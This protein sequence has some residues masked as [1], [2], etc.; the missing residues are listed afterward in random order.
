M[1]KTKKKKLFKQIKKFFLN[2]SNF[3]IIFIVYLFVTLSAGLLLLLPISQQENQNVKFIDALFTA[4]S[5]FSDTGLTTLTTVT[6]WSDFGQ[7]LILILILSGGIG[8]FAL[9]FFLINVIFNKS[10]SINSRN[11][12]E[13]E[14]GTNSS[15]ELK[16]TI[17]VSVSF[18]FI[19]ILIA[20]MVLWLIFY[21]ET[22]V[23][24]WTDN[25]GQVHD[26][27]K[28]DPK[29]RVWISFKC[30]FFHAI[31]A[32]NNAGFDILSDS[33]LTPYYGVYSIQIV[34][35]ILLIIGGIGFPVIYDVLKFISYKFRKRTDFKFSLFSKVS[36]LTYL[37]V[38]LI[39]FGFVLIFEIGNKNGIWWTSSTKTGSYSNKMM[40]IIF[41]VFSTRNAGFTTLDPNTTKFT[42]ASL[43]IFAIMMFI[44]SAPSSTAGGIRTTTLA[45][46]VMSVWNKMR[47]IQGVR[48]F[49][50]NVDNE[51]IYSSFMVFVL[52]IFIVLTTSLICFTSLDTIWGEADSDKLNF[53]DIF[54]DVCSA[55]GTTGLSTGLTSSLN[56]ISKLAI[57]LTMFIGQL[58]ISSTLLVWKKTN[59]KD[60]FSYIH[61]N[62]LIG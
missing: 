56:L 52:S 1:N 59:P 9:K 3:Q 58:G 39:G 48:A 61:E 46:I 33:S 53:A 51:T 14:R 50:R 8:I 26:Y 12:L 22:G 32:I 16:K 44:G 23:F 49:K 27:T 5:A 18:L 35:I 21:Y 6:T 34:F 11:V 60:N 43:V 28:Y 37:I 10:I 25:N 45:I 13:K 41:H 17:K 29:G 62:I 47:G 30:A 36:C 54:Y 55:F 31:S 7:L 19:T 2:M 57:I 24:K 38:F 40:C 42:N 4:A 15:G 20:T